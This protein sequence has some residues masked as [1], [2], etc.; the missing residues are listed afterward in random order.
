MTPVEAWAAA[1]L[2][3]AGKRA[4]ME[5]TS[6]DRQELEAFRQRAGQVIPGELERTAIEG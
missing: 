2:A 6:A 5:L 3:I 1:Q 4:E